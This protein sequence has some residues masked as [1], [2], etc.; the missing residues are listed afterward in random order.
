M[1][2]HLPTI[3]E[4]VEQSTVVPFVVGQTVVLVQKDLILL[5]Q[6]QTLVQLVRQFEMALYPNSN[7]FALG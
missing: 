7:D 1:D 4:S 2:Y 6:H 3:P 5:D